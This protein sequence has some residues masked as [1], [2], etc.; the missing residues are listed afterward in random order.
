[1]ISDE[2]EPFTPTKVL[3]IGAHADDIDFA[4]AG[5]MAVWAKEGAMVEYV[6]IT[7]G[8]KGSTELTVT[9]DAMAATRQQEQKAAAEVLGVRD[10]HFLGYEDGQLECTRE[11]RKDLVRLIRQ[12]KPDTVV[13]IDPTMV[14]SSK[15]GIINHPDHRAAGQATLDAIYPLARDHLSYPELYTDEHL[16][17]HKVTHVLLL[18]LEKQNCFM[19]I[20][21]TFDLKLAALTKHASQGF[22]RQ[23]VID[24]VTLFATEAGRAADCRYAEAFVRID[25]PA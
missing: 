2:F 7:D 16:E 21:D 9:P 10:V 11:V 13:A 6:V 14:Y 18:N 20:T 5:S 22:A 12:T 19:D 3:A 23:Q 15:F 8:S 17:P 24:L 4:A 1:M 25:C